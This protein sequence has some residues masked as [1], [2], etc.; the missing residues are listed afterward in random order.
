MTIL[1]FVLLSAVTLASALFLVV[2]RN[3]VHGALCLVVTLGCLAV[4]YLMLGAEFVAVVQ[5]AVYAGAIMVLFLF[6]LMLLN[7]Q[8]QEGLLAERP[9]Y[10]MA[11]AVIMGA[12]LLAEVVVKAP[13]GAY[14][15]AAGPAALP[16]GFGSPGQV[17][18]LLFSRYLLPFELTSVVLLV[19]MVGAV[20][21]AR[22]RDAR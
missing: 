13:H 20:V 16:P 18:M 12:L 22:R 19:A 14:A 3:A 17:G 4:F 21:L 15:T 5:V 6:V 11:G 9:G 8:G 10:Q 7:V 2:L 1:P